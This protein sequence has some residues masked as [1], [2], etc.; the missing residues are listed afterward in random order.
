MA[1]SEQ[2]SAQKFYASVPFNFQ[3]SGNPQSTKY[4]Y[5]KGERYSHK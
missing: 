2:E 1:L 5:D 3:K 4:G